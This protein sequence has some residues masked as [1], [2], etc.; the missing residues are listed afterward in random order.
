MI[1]NYLAGFAVFFFLLAVNSQAQDVAVIATTA[2]VS[3]CNLTAAENVV[4]RIFNYGPTDLSGMNIPVSYS[5]NG[6]AA[7]NEVANFV[8][9]LP[10]STATYTFTTVADLSTPGTYTIDASTG[11]GGDTNPTNDAFSGYTVTNTAPSVGGTAM[12]ATNG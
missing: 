1:R 4:I 9:F 12:R 8:S 6:G 11:L 3:A 2:P 5:I 7:V 10:N